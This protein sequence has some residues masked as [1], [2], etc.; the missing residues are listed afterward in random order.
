M[1][2]KEHIDTH[3]KSFSETLKIAIVQFLLL[4]LEYLATMQILKEYII[5]F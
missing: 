1:H 2:F 3:N 4:L 5:Y